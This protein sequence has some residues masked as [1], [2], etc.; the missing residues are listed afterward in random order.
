MHNFKF[1]EY[2]KND[3]YS[4]N[5]IHMYHILHHRSFILIHYFWK[6]IINNEMTAIWNFAYSDLRTIFALKFFVF[7]IPFIFRFVFAC[8]VSFQDSFMKCLHK[9]LLTI[10]LFAKKVNTKVKISYNFIVINILLYLHIVIYMSPAINTFI[11]LNTC[12][13]VIYVEITPQKYHFL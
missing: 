12:I 1:K 6:S 3:T 2:L 10:V 13:N 8:S 5:I 7:E 4:P 9:F 11:F